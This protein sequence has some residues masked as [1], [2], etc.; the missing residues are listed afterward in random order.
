[1]KQ[2]AAAGE[3]TTTVPAET[4]TMAPSVELM[5]YAPEIPLAQHTLEQSDQE[6]TTAQFF[7]PMP[8][9]EVYPAIE[10]T[11]DETGIS[12]T[13]PATTEEKVYQAEISST[14]DGAQALVDTE[15]ET[16]N[17]DGTDM[18]AIQ[19]ANHSET[20]GSI[21][22]THI[23][24]FEEEQVE[25]TEE[26]AVNLSANEESTAS[27]AEHNPTETIVAS[28]ETTDAKEMAAGQDTQDKKPLES[29]Q[30]ENQSAE[31]ASD[32]HESGGKTN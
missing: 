4:E 5:P 19:T 25:K 30:I 13:I 17:T 26:T 3:D 2:S 20:T 7:Y 9:S 12:L 31:L 10:K 15:V 22:A 27:A 16:L 32:N 24:T 28:S 1:M 23:I 21:S 8:S 6:A 18:P 14:A 11:P 29:Q